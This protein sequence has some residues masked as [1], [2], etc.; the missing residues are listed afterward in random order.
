MEEDQLDDLEV[1][2]ELATYGPR[3]GFGPPR[4]IIRPAEKN[5]SARDLLQIVA[6][7]QQRKLIE[8]Q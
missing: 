2:H 1:D 6:I 7:L 4:K 8:L 5:H 3:A